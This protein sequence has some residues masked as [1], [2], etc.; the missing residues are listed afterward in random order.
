VIKAS[1]SL[2]ESQ[3]Q[4]ERKILD[5]IRG[6][7][8]R[9]LDSARAPIIA[10]TRQLVINAI[11]ESP[12]YDSI[13]SGKLQDEFGLRNPQK[14]MDAILAAWSNSLVVKINKIRVQGK[15]LMGG[16]SITM[17][18]SDYS[19][20][21]NLSDAMYTTEKGSEIRWLDWL[22]NYGDQAIILDYQIE[23]KPTPKSRAGGVVMVAS[24]G[25]SW[26]VPPEFSGIAGK[27]F[28]TDAVNT[29]EDE[30]AALVTKEVT[31]RI[32]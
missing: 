16:I 29:V 19:D 2:K 12:T 17:I 26:R 14:N 31:K 4:I 9:A 13:V 3:G 27:N 5:A 10:G 7:V 22:L 23:Y 18:P 15:K 11:R 20:V 25:K 24:R 1:L 6:V 28:V 30:V 8:N 21:I 32:K